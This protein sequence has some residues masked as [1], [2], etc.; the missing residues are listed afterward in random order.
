MHATAQGSNLLYTS[1]MEDCL[2]CKITSKQ[3][4]AFIIHETDDVIVFQSLENHPL[5]V[6]KQ[7]FEDIFDIESDIAE[8]LMS[9]AV[10]VAKAVKESLGCEGI[11]LVQS[12]GAMAGQDIF[13][14][15][16]HVKPRWKNDS[17]TINWD[18]EPRTEVERSETAQRIKEALD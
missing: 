10:K 5:I 13:H 15:H 17:V 18:I 3:L 4:D 6:P 9:E 2:F 7:H 16:L 1:I 8:K 12:S 11:N 14:F